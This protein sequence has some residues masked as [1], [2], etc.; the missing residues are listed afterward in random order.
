MTAPKTNTDRFDSP[1]REP[2]KVMRLFRLGSFHQTR[3]S[4]VRTLIRRMG[5]EQWKI[6]IFDKQLDENGIGHIIYRI[7]TPCESLTF[8]GFSNPLS[9]SERTDRVIAEKWDAT[10]VLSFGAP[11]ESKFDALTNEVPLQ[12]LGRFSANE[13]ILSRAN[14]SVRLFEKLVHLLSIGEQPTADDIKEVGYLMRTTAVYGNG[15]FGLADFDKVKLKGIFTLPFQAEMLSVYLTRQFTLDLVEHCALMRGGDKAIKLTRPVRRMLGIGNATGLGMAP[16]LINHPKLL[17]NWVMA[18]E[19]ALVRVRS[20]SR[21]CEK[22]IEKIF[23]LVHRCQIHMT[24]W[25]T[26]DVQQ[27]RAIRSIEKGLLKIRKLLTEKAWFIEPYPWD[28]LIRWAETSIDVEAQELLISILMEPYGNLVDDLETTNASDEQEETEP[29]MPLGVLKEFIE[30]SYGWALKRNYSGP[31]GDKHF[32]YRSAEK[33]EPRFGNRYEE[34]GAHLE[35]PIGVARDVAYLYKKLTEY[36]DGVIT[37]EF[38]MIC[39]EFRRIVRRVQSLAECPYAEI[40]DNLIGADCEPID[41]LRCKLSIFGAT[42]FDPK[43]KLWTRIVLFQGAPLPDELMLP[44]ADDW[45]A[46]IF[47][48]EENI[49]GPQ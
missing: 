32:W 37:A 7:D 16:Y 40:R 21:P 43:S 38:L 41:I 18:R 33:E 3:I 47:S 2:E 10:F 24:E 29:A 45:F 5:R 4:F 49:W 36:D 22:D 46:P 14:K 39:P 48:R 25:R 17:N 1:L 34:P 8:S 44:D 19:T 23:D 9:P 6:T 15:K 31:D 42:K 27:K 30:R 28:R 35:M 12:E 13:F 20:I 26:G 11:G